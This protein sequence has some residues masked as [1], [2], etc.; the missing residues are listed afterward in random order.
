MF[1]VRFSGDIPGLLLGQAGTFAVAAV[2]GSVIGNE[3]LH[4]WGLNGYKNAA[5]FCKPL[6]F[7]TDG[8]DELFVGRAGYLCGALWLQKHLGFQPIPEKVRL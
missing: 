6:H 7:L 4:N 1:I 5:Q 2:F 8:S 3:E